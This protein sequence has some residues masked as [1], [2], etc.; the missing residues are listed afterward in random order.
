MA[1]SLRLH[2]EL[3]LLALSTD[4]GTIPF[5]RM[6]SLG[7]GGALLTELLLANRVAIV[8]EGRGARK[9]FVEVRGTSPFGEAV[10]DDALVKLAGAKRRA[11][12]SIAVARLSELPK[13]QHAVAR[14]LCQRGILRETEDR[15][16]LLFRR[17]V[18]PTVDHQPRQEV[19]RRIRSVVDGSATLDERTA[20]LIGLAALTS[21]LSAIY[22]RRALRVRSNR[23]KRLAESG[24]GNS[25]VS[26]SIVAIRAAM[27]DAIPSAS[28]SAD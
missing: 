14:E 19:I 8:S 22:D 26:Q 12:A 16:L 4:K 17:R 10:L 21:A 5:G 15:I 23:L 24:G 27:I 6:V 7:L 28:I 25:A 18:F 1:S 2:H 3:L 9:Q 20:A 13:L 11:Y